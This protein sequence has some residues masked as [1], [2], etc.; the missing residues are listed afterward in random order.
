MYSK[1][2]SPRLTSQQV[3]QLYSTPWS[4][5]FQ[6]KDFDTVCNATKAVR[7]LSVRGRRVMGHLLS[8]IWNGM[9]IWQAQRTIGMKTQYCRQ[10]INEVM[11][12]GS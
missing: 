8:M 10:T 7:N 4:G 12:F 6:N 5:P 1:Y 11:R 9:P 3:I 2:S